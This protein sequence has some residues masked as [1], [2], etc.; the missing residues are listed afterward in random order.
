[1]A[2]NHAWHVQGHSPISLITVMDPCWLH[3][4]QSCAPCVGGYLHP[5][6][7]GVPGDIDTCRQ[8]RRGLY[9]PTSVFAQ[10]GVVI[11]RSW[12]AAT[13]K[14]RAASYF[15]TKGGAVVL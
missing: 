3:V 12:A 6:C 15:S 7:Y 8:S 13:Y 2:T 10:D 5:H 4:T 1:M 14:G 9:M 11:C